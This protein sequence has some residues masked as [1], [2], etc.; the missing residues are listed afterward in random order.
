MRKR[1]AI[2]KLSHAIRERYGDA[3]SSI[4][5]FGSVARHTAGVDSDIDI[6]VLMDPE[7]QPVGWRM[8]RDIRSLALPV[9]LEEDVVFDLK[10]ACI[11]DLAGLRGHTPFMERVQ[12]EGV[13]V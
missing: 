10:V 5:V 11:T 7:K 12:T 9:E 1:R 13:P 3:V 8:Q 4:L 6:M 2:D